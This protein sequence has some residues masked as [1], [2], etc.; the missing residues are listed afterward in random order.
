[1]KKFLSRF[2]I[3]ILAV[4]MLTPTW[5]TTLWNPIRAEAAE[6]PG[7]LSAEDFGVVNYDTGLGILKGYTAGFGL[8]DA[9]F[10][11]AQSITARLYGA[12]NQLLQT[13]T[14][15]LKVGTLTGAQAITSPFDVSGTFDYATD[16]YWN[17]VRE[18]EY[19]QSIPATKIVETV[20]LASGKV[21]TAENTNLTGDPTTIMLTGTLSAEDFGVVNYNTGATGQF[22]GYTSGFGLDDATFDTATSIIVKLYAGSQLLQTNSATLKV[23]TL[24]GAQTITSPFDV[25]GT[26]DYALDGYWNNVREAEYGQNIAATK[27]VATVVLANGKIVTAT[28]LSPTGDLTKPSVPTATPPAGNYQTSQSVTL[29]SSDNLSLA[30]NIRIYYTLDGTCPSNTSTLYTGAITVDHDLALS[31]IAYD[32]AGNESPVLTAV[33]DIAPAISAEGTASAATTSATIIWTTI[34]SATSRVI[35]DTVSHS[36]IAGYAEGSNYGY[37]SSTALYSGKVTSHSVALT[38]LTPGTTYYYRTISSGSPETV[39][40]EMSFTT[41]AAPV[42]TT[43][44]VVSAPTVSPSTSSSPSAVTTPTVTT[45]TEQGQ[46]KGATTTE[47][48]ESEKINWTPWII[49]FILILLA[50]AATGGYFY[51]FGRDDEEEEIITKKVIEKNKKPVAKV[52][53]KNVEKAS[54][55]KSKRW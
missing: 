16:G 1:M 13:D 45:P 35:Y 10:D 19:G 49:L 9:T 18:I 8:A 4:G 28:N 46:I 43:V 40:A 14:A 21:V 12:N 44:A 50:G 38:G 17:N 51:W 42:V 37:A 27:V 32:E 41:T 55:K 54:P 20:V 33:Y 52:A 23:G 5:I 31:A 47:N 53:P 48:Q 25:L 22:Y 3:I 15:T 26:F 6:L 24:T 11:T 34:Q 29:S 30:D 7:T 36:S 39:G 2:L